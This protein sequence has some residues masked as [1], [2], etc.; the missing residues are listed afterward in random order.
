M[1]TDKLGVPKTI[2]LSLWGLIVIGIIC[3]LAP[4]KEVF[5]IS[6][7]S[8]GLFIGPCQSASRVW[9][10]LVAPEEDRASLFGLLMMSGKLTS[11]FGPLFYG[12]LVLASGTD[13]IGMLI[14]PLLLGAGLVLM[15]RRLTPPTDS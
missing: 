3:I 4:T 11:F 9:V 6:G 10:S 8:L 12:W 1:I 5:W 15:P 14:V 13:R 7:L 2:R